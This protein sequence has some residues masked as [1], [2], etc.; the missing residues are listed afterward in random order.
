[1]IM[2]ERMIFVTLVAI[3]MLGMQACFSSSTEQT[4]STVPS[5]SQGQIDCKSET[6]KSS[7]GFFF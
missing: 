6:T 4:A 5:C 7:W 1:M 3:A 2:F